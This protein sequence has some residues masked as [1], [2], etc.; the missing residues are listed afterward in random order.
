MSRVGAGTICPVGNAAAKQLEHRPRERH[1]VGGHPRR[2]DVGEQARLGIAPEGDHRAA[3]LAALGDEPL[4]PVGD[5]SERVP[6]CVA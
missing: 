1:L 5:E 4:P 2:L 3:S 6:G